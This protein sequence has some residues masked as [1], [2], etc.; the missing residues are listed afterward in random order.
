MK[1]LLKKKIPLM[2]FRIL[3]PLPITTKTP[4]LLRIKDLITILQTPIQDPN[5]SN[6]PPNNPNSKSLSKLNLRSCLN[7]NH[8]YSPNLKLSKNP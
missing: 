3:I 7:P 4:Q 1:L 8:N 2:I 6:N 5:F